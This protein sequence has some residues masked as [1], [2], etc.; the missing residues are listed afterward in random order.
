MHSEISGRRIGIVSM[1]KHTNIATE[2]QVIVKLPNGLWSRTRVAAI[3]RGEHVK[4]FVARA[5][6]RAVSLHARA[7][8][9]SDLERA[10][11]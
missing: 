9:E 4:V 6:E 8:E 5:L 3:E 7:E 10:R 11:R 2:K 1:K